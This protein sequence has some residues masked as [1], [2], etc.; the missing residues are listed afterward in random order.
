MLDRYDPRDDGRERGDSWDRNCG[1]R[2]SS[3][4]RDRE[5]RS[6][7]VFTKDLIETYIETKRTKD[8]DYIR[9][10][11]HPSEFYLYYDA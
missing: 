4:E 11:P 7:D 1:S 3:S 5:E 9:L 6:R 8:V 2:G 10:R